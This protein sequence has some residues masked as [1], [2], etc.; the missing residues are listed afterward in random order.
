MAE[1]LA[2]LNTGVVGKLINGTFPTT[3]VPSGTYTTIG[4]M[5]LSAGHTYIICASHQYPT[6]VPDIPT[7]MRIQVG[8]SNKAIYRNS[9]GMY[10]GGG[11][12][13]TA[14]IKLTSNA[15]A[16]FDA[17][18]GSGSDKTASSVNFTAYQLD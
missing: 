4:T 7:V 9:N 15:I 10:N 11:A 16:N 14:I 13:L 2:E 3:T 18:Q 17:W 5:N 6:S 8:G 1:K 12:S